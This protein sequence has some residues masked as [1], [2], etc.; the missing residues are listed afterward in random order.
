MILPPP[1]DMFS[2]L[3]FLKD[4]GVELYKENVESLGE[5]IEAPKWIQNYRSSENQRLEDEG[6]RLATELQTVREKLKPFLL[7]SASVY[8]TSR[9]LE[10]AVT[11]IFSD[12]GWNVEDL[13]KTGQSIDYVIRRRK[14]I[15]KSLV[16]ALT[17]TTGYI[18]SKSAKLAQLLGVFPEVGDGG[19]LVFLVNGSIEIDPAAVLFRTTSL[20]RHSSA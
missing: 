15:S 16:V 8:S 12:L 19:R 9:R 1:D 18:G 10:I 2:A 13:T 11:K 6:N 17:G 3:L 14:E 20:T 7:A 4:S 5:D